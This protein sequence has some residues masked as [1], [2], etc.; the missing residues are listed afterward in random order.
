GLGGRNMVR[1]RRHAIK[2]HRLVELFA[3]PLRVDYFARIQDDLM[4][5][6]DPAPGTISE[7]VAASRPWENHVRGSSPTWQN[8]IEHRPANEARHIHPEYSCGR[9]GRS[10]VEEAA[11][12]PHTFRRQLA[13]AKTSCGGVQLRRA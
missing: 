4:R 8:R 13:G 1:N 9:P 11:V 3:A 2:L 12:A 10:G 6:R 5:S 7:P